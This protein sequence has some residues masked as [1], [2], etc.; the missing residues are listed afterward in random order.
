MGIS[1]GRKKQDS[2]VEA[3]R[4]QDPNTFRAVHQIIYEPLRKETFS[5]S[6]DIMREISGVRHD[7]MKRVF[8]LD[9]LELQEF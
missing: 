2:A 9:A 4:K 6:K 8:Y 3:I 1:G 5:K 7:L